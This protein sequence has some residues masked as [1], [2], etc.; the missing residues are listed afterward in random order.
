MTPRSSPSSIRNDAKPVARRCARS[1]TGRRLASLQPRFKIGNELKL[2]DA[3]FSLA[4]SRRADLVRR[5]RS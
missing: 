1:M 4:W 3:E 2:I 5:A